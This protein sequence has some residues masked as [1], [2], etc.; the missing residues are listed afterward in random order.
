MHQDGERSERLRRRAAQARGT[1]FR[2][3][4]RELEYR[5]RTFGPQSCR[6][7]FAALA[8]DIREDH[9]RP[10]V[11]KRTG[12][13]ASNAGRGSGDQCDIPFE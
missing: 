8:L 12:N 4:I 13:S 10:L 5:L 2:S 6:C 9:T 1:I 11:R 3:Q 7:S